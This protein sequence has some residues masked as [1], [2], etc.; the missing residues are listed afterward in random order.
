M[1][2]DD[3]GRTAD[4]IARQVGG[5]ELLMIWEGARSFVHPWSKTKTTVKVT[6]IEV[7]NEEHL[8]Q[9]TIIP[10]GP[11]RSIGRSQYCA[12]QMSGRDPE[13]SFLVLLCLSRVFSKSSY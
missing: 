5:V 13:H 8:R 10:F 11:L 3:Y 9:T 7:F 4:L 2:H 1:A 12:V 6:D